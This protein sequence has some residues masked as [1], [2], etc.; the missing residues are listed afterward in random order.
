MFSARSPQTAG[1]ISDLVIHFR[2]AKQASDIYP[3]EEFD[4]FRASSACRS[5][6]DVLCNNSEGAVAIIVAAV[7]LQ[8]LIDI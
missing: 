4:G 3:Q 6:G 8:I 1:L 2:C 5:T 7:V